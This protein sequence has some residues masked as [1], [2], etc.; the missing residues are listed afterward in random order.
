[1]DKI[2]ALV[3]RATTEGPCVNSEFY[4]GLIDRLIRPYETLSS[5]NCFN[6]R[7]MRQERVA[8]QRD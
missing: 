3:R 8:L 2:Q 6:E 4:A 1:M 5:R 7:E